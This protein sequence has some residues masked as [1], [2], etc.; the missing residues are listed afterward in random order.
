M[1]EQ[2]F[3]ENARSIFG[4]KIKGIFSIFPIKRLLKECSFIIS[5]FCAMVFSILVFI[6]CRNEMLN[7]IEKIITLIIAIV[8]AI[9]GLSLAGF[10]IVISQINNET[11]E[12][13]A[14][15]ENKNQRS[16]YQKTNAVFSIMCLTQLTALIL[17]TILSLV[18]QISKKILVS[19]FIANTVNIT[20]IFLLVFIC[21]YALFSV[22]DIIYT[23]FDLGQIV[24]F[25]FL[26]NR[27]K[28]ESASLHPEEPQCPLDKPE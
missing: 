12:R 22:F 24:N 20:L 15:I 25:I 2:D 9:L 4:M 23:I 26:K 7:I 21:V 13:T 19:Y 1:N 27:I 8:P 10:A 5:L 11:L 28:K 17:A 16:L 6:I 18:M 3:N 14:N